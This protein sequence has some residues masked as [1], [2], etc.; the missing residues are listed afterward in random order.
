MGGCNN[1]GVLEHQSG[2]LAEARRLFTMACD[3]GQKKGCEALG[4][5]KRE[6]GQ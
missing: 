1:L 4:I 6:A 2:N 5:L 3:G